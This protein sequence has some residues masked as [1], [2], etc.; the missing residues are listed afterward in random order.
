VFV[1][2]DIWIME[3]QVLRLEAG[4][5]SNLQFKVVRCCI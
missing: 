2:D 5:P 1:D 3:G 4:Q